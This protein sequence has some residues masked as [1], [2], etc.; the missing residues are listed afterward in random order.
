MIFKTRED[1]LREIRG[2]WIRKY[3]WLPVS[4]CRTGRWIWLE[5]YEERVNGWYYPQGD[6][7]VEYS[8]RYGDE[9]NTPT[10]NSE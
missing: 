5:P 9:L 6:L 10:P 2:K 7:T 1:E 3:A 4:V 8:Y